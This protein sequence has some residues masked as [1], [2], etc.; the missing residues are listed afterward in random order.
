MPAPASPRTSPPVARRRAPWRD[1]AAWVALVRF[2]LGFELVFFPLYFGIGALTAAS[3]RARALHFDW[4]L[5]IP[6]VDWMVLP[7]LLVIPSFL[8]PIL[9]LDARRIDALARQT[10]AAV[11]IAAAVFLLLPGRIG[12]APV[13]AEGPLAPLLRFIAAIDTPHNTFPSLHVAC[14]VLIGRACADAAGPRPALAYHLWLALALASTL[15]THQHHLA[16]VAGGLALA[17]ALRRWLPIPPAA[18]PVIRPGAD[19]A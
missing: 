5:A 1:R 19:G 15:L 4:E 16:D 13:P 18:S 2:C 8:L 11:V 10:I 9:H 17:L 3:G 14:A 12:H 6:R 7:Y